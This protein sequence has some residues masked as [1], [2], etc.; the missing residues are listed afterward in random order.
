VPH[1]HREHRDY[2]S[3]VLLNYD[4]SV[5]DAEDNLTLALVRPDSTTSAGHQ[6]RRQKV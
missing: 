6:D 5:N 4:D 3:V 1:H 2:G